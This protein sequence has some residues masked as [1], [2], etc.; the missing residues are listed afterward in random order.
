MF[1]KGE[2][3]PSDT[4]PEVTSNTEPECDNQ[5]P[6]HPLLKLLRTKPIGT[7]N[8]VIPPTDLVQTSNV[9]DKT[10]HVTEKESLVKAIKKK[11]QTKSPSVPDPSLDK[12]VDSS[13]EQLLLTLMKECSIFQSTDHIT[14]EHLKKVVVKKTMFKLKA[15][16][17]QATSSRKALK[18][19]KPFIPYKYCG[20]NDHHSDECEYYPG[21]DICGSIA[22]E[23]YNYDKKT[24]PNNKKPRIAIQLSNKPTKKWVHKRN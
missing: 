12:K 16:S 22:H 1:T 21:L 10:K 18:I 17:S 19:P 9:S 6:L 11:A 15:Q 23:R 4:A 24:L 8:D 5:E 14:K 7:S 20:F 2:N 3:S 13:T